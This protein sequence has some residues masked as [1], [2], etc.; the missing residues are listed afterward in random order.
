MMMQGL[1]KAEFHGSSRISSTVK[2]LW[3][4]IE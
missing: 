3:I 4:K 2:D 1:W